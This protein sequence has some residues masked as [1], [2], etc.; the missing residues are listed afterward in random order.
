MHTFRARIV[1]RCNELLGIFGHE[2][3]LVIPLFEGAR[4]RCL[5]VFDVE[6]TLEAHIPI[7]VYLIDVEEIWVA[8]L[9]L[10]T[11]GGWELCYASPVWNQVGHHW[12]GS[13]AMHGIRE[14]CAAVTASTS[15]AAATV[16]PMLTSMSCVENPRGCKRLLHWDSNLLDGRDSEWFA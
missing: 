10:D 11:Q 14:Q 9:L 2:G 13:S 12:G 5:P 7:I 3:I 6:S 4:D 8:T 16:T 15:T 1:H